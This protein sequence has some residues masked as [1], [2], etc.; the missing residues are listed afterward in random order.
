MWKWCIQR[1]YQ[2]QW[3]KW[4]PRARRNRQTRDIWYSSKRSLQSISLDYFFLIEELKVNNVKMPSIV[5]CKNNMTV[6][7]SI[8]TNTCSRLF[9]VGKYI[10]KK[11][12]KDWSQKK[13]VNVTSMVIKITS[14]LYPILFDIY[15]TCIWDI[16]DYC[17]LHSI[18][19]WLSIID[20][21]YG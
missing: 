12:I 18:C 6:E 7:L 16:W 4:I 3:W 2:R 19:F 13:A 5:K 8:S 17:C 9:I 20:N 10:D 11:D 14:Y 1:I 15:P 21:R